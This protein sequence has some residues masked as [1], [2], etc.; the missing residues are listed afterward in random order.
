MKYLYQRNNGIITKYEQI[1]K[2]I[3]NFYINTSTNIAVNIDEILLLGKIN[4]NIIELLEDSDFV[5]LEYKS[6]KYRKRITRIFEV[7]KLD[8]GFITFENCHC[9]F[10]IKEN[11]KKITDKICKNIKIKSVLTHEE[12]NKGKV[13]I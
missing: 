3:Q 9:Y 11:A 10:F 12:F 6:P 4:K 2:H 7:S 5:E 1:A 13:N 8:D